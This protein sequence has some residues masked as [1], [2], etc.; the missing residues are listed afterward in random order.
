MSLLNLLIIGHGSQAKAWSKNLQISGVKVTIGLR[1]TSSTIQTVKN[2]GFDWIEIDRVREKLQFDAIILLTPDDSHEQILNLI[3]N[4]LSE[5]SKIIYAHGFSVSKNKLNEKFP[6]FSHLLLAPKAIASEVIELFL[7]K[8]PIPAAFSLEFSLHPSQD[9]IFIEQLANSLG[10]TGKLV[11]TNFQEETF[12]DLFSEQSILCS[13]LPRVIKLSYDTLIK[14]GIS[15]ELAFL[16]C[17]L[18]AKYILNTLIKIGFKDFFEIISPNALIGAEKAT[19]LFFT[20]EFEHKF[21]Q[22]FQEIQSGKFYEEIAT[23]QIDTIRKK[24]VSL[25]NEGDIDS[26]RILLKEYLN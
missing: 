10:M 1:S 20:H 6:K 8:K 12:C 5:K 7:E 13:V 23:T 4:Y 16:E 21:D 22:L 15:N 11:Q 17:C 18:E 19:K 26:T 14:N 25:Y 24:M 3:A 9:L 2:N